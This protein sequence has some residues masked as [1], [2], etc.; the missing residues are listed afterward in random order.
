ML[1]LHVSLSLR[2]GVFTNWPKEMNGFSAC[3]SQRVGVV[4]DL[5]L[6]IKKRGNQYSRRHLPAGAPSVLLGVEI[7]TLVQ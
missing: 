2:T 7:S 3:H 5:V 1:P 4:K 6:L